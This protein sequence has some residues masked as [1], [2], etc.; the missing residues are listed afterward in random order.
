MYIY[1]YSS[2]HVSAMYPPP[3]PQI[4]WRKKKEREK[5]TKE[6]KCVIYFVHVCTSKKTF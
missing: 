2:D 6:K 4:I 3:H 5:N 1:I